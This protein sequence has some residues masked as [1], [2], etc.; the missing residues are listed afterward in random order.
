MFTVI[1]GIIMLGI[2]VFV[3]EFGHFC[4]AKLTGVKVLKFSLGFGP[5][6]IS[7]TWGETEYMICA[8]PLGGY[9]QML[10]EGTGEEGEEAEL[11]PEERKRSFGEKAV[12]QRTAI[13][14]AGPFMNLLLPFLVL[15][16]AYMVGVNLPAFL[17]G[18]PCVGYVVAQ[19][20]AGS[21]GF[22]AGDCIV[23]INGEAVETWTDTNQALISNAGSPLEFAVERGG[24]GDDPVHSQIRVRH[25]GAPV[26][27]RA[28][29]PRGGG[30]GPGPGDAGP[31]GRVP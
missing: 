17:E 2:L 6:L 4:V 29:A 16:L 7:K 24:A 5:R 27:R 10:G 19:S 8:V 21:A 1:V 12:S 25:R 11:T 26:P 30:W 15:P 18:S 22:A 31:G 28:S 14:A 3:H 20:E 13:V 23:A 9:V